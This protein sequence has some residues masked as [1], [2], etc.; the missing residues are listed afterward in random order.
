MGI[1]KTHE[2]INESDICRCDMST[3][4]YVAL[5]LNGS[6][7]RLFRAR[8]SF[9]PISIIVPPS[10][11]QRHDSSRRFP[12]RE[13]KMTSTPLPSVISMIWEAKVVDLEEKMCSGG[14]PKVEVRNSRFL[15]LPTVAK[16]WK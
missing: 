16:T 3:P 4:R 13:F 5:R 14:I 2:A 9:F 10:E 6:M 12:V 11:I 8:T 1:E 7:E 15:S